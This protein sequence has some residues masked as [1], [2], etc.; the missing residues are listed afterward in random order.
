MTQRSRGAERPPDTATLALFVHVAET[1]SF[2]AAAA[3]ASLTT[4]S[5]SRRLQA[6]E[7]RLG[8]RL[9]DRTSRRVSMTEAGER[10]YARCSR[11]LEELYEAEREVSGLGEVPRG[12]LRVTAP[13][14]LGVL[15]IAPLAASLLVRHPDLRLDLS[16]SDAVV[17]LGEE[18]LDVAVR[19]AI[20][21]DPALAARR[22]GVV[23][24][25]VCASPAYLERRGTPRDPADLVRHDLLHLRPVSLRREWGF[26]GLD[27]VTASQIKAS[28]DSMLAL[29]EA[30]IAGLG[31]ARLPGYVAAAA[32]RSGALRLLIP[33]APSEEIGTFAVFRPGPRAPPKVRAFVNHL[34]RHL[35]GR[36]GADATL[37]A[38]G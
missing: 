8:V 17:N 7:A 33:D 28:L 22:I 18:R 27:L 37:L 32:L 34:A 12:L 11:I 26:S 19:F 29:H 4:S 15:H 9:L 31:V 14:D 3:E 6:L 24:T 10:L 21:I 25:V 30:A 1:G 16:L 35:P 23:R 2:T 5:V 38:P 13:T 36:L 20:E